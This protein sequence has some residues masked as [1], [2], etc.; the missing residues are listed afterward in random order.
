MKCISLSMS[1]L[2]YATISSSGISP[3]EKMFARDTY[4]D[5]L[6][7][8][9]S[10]SA[11]PVKS[12]TL[13]AQLCTKKKN[14]SMS[15]ILD[16]FMSIFSFQHVTLFSISFRRAHYSATFPKFQQIFGLVRKIPNS[17]K[18]SLILPGSLGIFITDSLITECFNTGRSPL[19][20]LEG[21]MQ[22]KTDGCRIPV[23]LP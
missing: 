19:R 5:Y 16:T 8:K 7:S 4:C 11:P 6:D 20:K 2:S 1:S 9:V 22:R 18:Q 3:L 13:S 23:S 12:P 15:L 17:H 10:L 14:F 21:D